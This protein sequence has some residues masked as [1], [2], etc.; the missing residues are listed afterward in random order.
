MGKQKEKILRRASGK[1]LRKKA[2]NVVNRKRGLCLLAGMLAGLALAKEETG[3]TALNAAGLTQ[4][5][6]T[7]VKEL[8]HTHSGEEGACYRN[9]HHPC[10]GAVYHAWTSGDTEIYGCVECG[11]LY[12]DEDPAIC[13]GNWEITLDCSVSGMGSFYIEKKQEGESACLQAGIRDKSSDITDHDISWNV[14]GA[15]ETDGISVIEISENRTYTA[16]LRWYDDKADMWHT[17]SLSYTDL[18]VPVRV[19]LLDGEELLSSVKIAYGDALPSVTPPEKK[20]YRF[21][22]FYSGEIQYYDE[23]GEPTGAD[24]EL[25]KPELKLRAGWEAKTYLLYFGEDADGDGMPDQSTSVAYGEELTLPHP[26][27][28]QNRTG[29]LFDGYWLGDTC[30][31]D[32][33]GVSCGKWILDPEDAEVCLEE[34][35]K[36]KEFD[37]SYEDSTVHVVYDEAYPDIRIGTAGIAEGYEAEGLYLDGDKVF[38]ADGRAAQGVWHWDLDEMEEETGLKL[39]T[40]PCPAEENADEEDDDEEDEQA[41]IAIQETVTVPPLPTEKEG[42]PQQSISENVLAETPIPY[43][44]PQ[45]QAEI[46]LPVQEEVQGSG[47]DTDREESDPQ[48]EAAGEKTEKEAGTERQEAGDEA[49]RAEP[50]MVE[51][52][53]ENT[54]AGNRN[55]VNTEIPKREQEGPHETEI[56]QMQSVE[57][58]TPVITAK[59]VAVAAA[60]VTGG[61]GALWCVYAGMIYFF[62]LAQVNTICTD[63]SKKFLGRVHIRAQKGKHF[64]MELTKA[65]LEQCETDRVLIRIPVVFA[66][67]FKNRALSVVAGSKKQ[68]IL[69]R[70][71]IYLTIQV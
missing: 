27:L 13:E 1:E 3:G 32:G 65:L 22:G 9:V 21:T 18:T 8:Q 42:Q 31:I 14:S 58:R 47:E 50:L 63:G 15:E 71:E 41:D 48:A 20:G 11:H 70:S 2:E 52:I 12:Y 56:R 59:T 45:P 29:Y 66:G 4:T 62:A 23:K 53:L 43:Q 69:M 55:T 5:T 49:E 46:L 54:D 16:T 10:S 7:Q 17:D 24:T 25:E 38:L 61:A 33:K 28:P 60:A 26:E 34:R 6:E 68:Q 67:L 37:I 30:V 64:E 44:E 39:K 19:D 51:S 36:A 57:K 35:W 40:V